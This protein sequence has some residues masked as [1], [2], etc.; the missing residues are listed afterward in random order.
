MSP[1]P[2]LR[3]FHPDPS[4]VRV[5]GWTYLVTSTFGWLPGLPVRRSRDHVDWEPLPSAIPD[6]R[7]LD[8]SDCACDDGLYA[9]GIRHDGE[10]FLLACTLVQRQKQRFRNFI[11]VSTRPEEG[12]SAPVMLPEGVG[13]IDPTPFVDD[14]GSLWLVL[15]DL[16]ATEGH[17]GA[18]RSIRLWRLDRDSFQPVDGPHMLWHGALVGTSTP[19]APRLFK[20]DG[21]YWLLIAEGGTGPNHAVTLARSRSITGPYEGCPSN[22]RL[23]HRHLDPDEPVQCVGH[24]DLLRMEDGSWRGCCLAVRRDGGLSLMGRETWSVSVDWRDGEWPVFAPGRGQLERRDPDA[25][26]P[27]LDAE[28]IGLREAPADRLRGID[29]P[30]TFLPARPDPLALV[31]RRVAEPS[32][33]WRVTL[34]PEEGVDAHG[35]ALFCTETHWLKLERSGGLLRLHSAD[36][37]EHARAEVPADGALTLEL[38]WSPEGA[39]AALETKEGRE[40]LGGR[41]PPAVYARPVFAGGVAALF[42]T[43]D[44]GGVRVLE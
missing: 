37:T 29:G 43:G 41:I 13:R 27:C 26:G 7:H 12:W 35:I 15:N 20:H 2:F 28:W 14:D 40:I 38:S 33:R 6:S 18:N 39:R 30:R 22:P 16:P 19:E 1:N 23:T 5:D 34:E 42:A 10:R 4:W 36:G 17:H 11:C 8:F 24:A 32:G 3:G 21:W 31:G 25:P 9:P 44:R